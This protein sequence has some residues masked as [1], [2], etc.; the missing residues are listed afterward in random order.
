M[1]RLAPAWGPT[2]EDVY[3][4]SYR[5]AMA[6]GDPEGWLDT[7]VRVVDGNLGLVDTKYHEKNEREKLIDLYYD[8]KALPGGRH[9]WMSGVP[10]RQFLFNCHRA[11][12]TDNISTHYAFAFD[13]LMQGG[14]VGA[15]YSNR[16]IKQYGAIKHPV[17]V[18]VTCDPDHANYDELVDMLSTDY[19]HE[20]NGSIRVEDSRE[21]WIH[22][23][24]SVLEAF[25]NGAEEII[26]DLSLIRHR[27][28]P[29]K[30]FGGTASGPGPLAIMLTQVADLLSSRVGMRLVSLDHMVIDHHIANCVVSGNVRR[31]ARMSIKH[32]ADTDI[33]DF[34]N[35]K[36]DENLHWSTN[37]SVEIDDAFFRALK[38]G[39]AHAVEVYKATVTGMV[40][41]G[42][43]GF[44]NVSLA[45]VGEL[46]DVG[47]TNPCGEIPL[48][49][50]ENCNLGHVNLDS[51]YN[52]FEGAC[53]AHRL[54]TR[55]LM[56][57][58][59][60]D[61]VN[62]KQRE[63][64]DRNRRIGVGHFGFQG[65]LVKQGIRYSDSHR[66]NYVRKTLK[67]FYEVVRKEARRY[68]F[69]LRIP[70]PIKVTTLA[71][72]G[73]IAKLPGG[74]EGGQAIYARHFKRRI[75]FSTV[76][77]NQIKQLETYAEMGFDIEDCMYT[78][79]TKVVTFYTKDPLVD[80]VAALGLDADSLVESTDEI[81]LADMLA[82]Q[83]MYQECWADNAVS[84]TVNVPAGNYQ[85]QWFTAKALGV[86][87]DTLGL[88][89]KEL[90]LKETETKADDV[91]SVLIHYLPK[92]KGTTLMVDGSR[93]QAPYERITQQE[94]ENY[95]GNHVISDGINEECATGACPIK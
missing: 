58:T 77:P 55:F 57:A 79:N 43:P 29:I 90:Y 24:V 95:Q 67:D 21:G 15:N 39:N 31:S 7:I 30:T 75:R 40:R 52:D 82:V 17:A 13:Q 62:P 10:G 74:T 9:L 86:S 69:E 65:W 71:P 59:F 2:G 94:Y 4:R 32:W 89:F 47:S 27:G 36:Q 60:G 22:A 23:L 76:D 48:E 8:M 68:A 73:T 92:L 88:E 12:W 66:D 45:S 91:A 54:M 87:M 33:L 1:T 41:N 78:P 25:W 20:W 6:N 83:A 63:V 70:E 14:G 50:W 5:R 49:N 84:F 28:A 61:V 72:T 37:I 51:F 81:S 26:L 64:V 56:R 11:G 3:Q 16:Y 80:K 42:E 53:E 35:C 18:H 93:P 38:K 44:Y 34:I 85:E 19:S 46:G